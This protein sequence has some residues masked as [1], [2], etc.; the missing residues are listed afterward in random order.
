MS[1]LHNS[2]YFVIYKLFVFSHDEFKFAEELQMKFPEN[3]TILFLYVVLSNVQS[4]KLNHIIH[5]CRE[6]ML[7]V[8]ACV[9][10]CKCN[11]H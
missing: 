7:R 5:K 10:V 8:A 4:S 9:S 1:E 3:R 11:D 6:E 2:L